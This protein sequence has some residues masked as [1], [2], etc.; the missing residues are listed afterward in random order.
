LTKRINIKDH[1]A[2]FLAGNM[3][4]G[5]HFHRDLTYLI[6]M[7]KDLTKTCYQMYAKQATGLSPEIV[8]FNIELN[9]NQP[10]IIVKVYFNF[11]R[12]KMFFFPILIFIKDNDAHNLLRPELVESLYYMY[13]LTNDT[14][15]QEWGWKIF[16]SFEKYTRQKDGYS[17]ISDVRHPNNV[18]PRDKMESFFLAETLKYFYLLFNETN[19]F[20]FNQWIFNTEAHL[21]PIY[22]N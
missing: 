2:C 22:T 16:Q 7:A 11:F 8:Y 13:H 3:A 9:S 10:T 12:K 1:L 18:R 20:P 6:D 19:L 15:Y 21:L 4:L 17:S 14:M 5:W